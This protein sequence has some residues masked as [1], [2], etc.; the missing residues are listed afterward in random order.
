MLPEGHRRERWSRMTSDIKKF[1]ETEE[2][3][4]YEALKGYHTLEIIMLT[5]DKVVDYRIVP[6]EDME[7]AEPMRTK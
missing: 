3:S 2:L 5:F 4:K 7:T 6:Y 1:H